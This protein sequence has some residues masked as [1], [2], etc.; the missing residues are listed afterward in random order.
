MFI[1]PKVSSGHVS[2]PFFWGYLICVTKRRYVLVVFFYYLTRK[3]G[4]VL[5]ASH[6]GEGFEFLSAIKINLE[7]SEFSDIM[8]MYLYGDEGI[9]TCKFV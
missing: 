3:L 6:I 7:L 1:T 2:L 9:C 8:E 5:I 4:W